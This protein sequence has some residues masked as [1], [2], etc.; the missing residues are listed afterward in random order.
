MSGIFIY[1]YEA[2]YFLI[3]QVSKEKAYGAWN[4]IDG[5]WRTKSMSQYSDWREGTWVTVN[6]GGVFCVDHVEIWY[7]QRLAR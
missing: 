5:S 1:E 3:L 6:L 7:F 4:A 2:F